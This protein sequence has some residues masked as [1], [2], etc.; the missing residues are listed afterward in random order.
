MV[1]EYFTI[2]DSVNKKYKKNYIA[3]NLP[4]I[5][6]NDIEYAK[7]HEKIIVIFLQE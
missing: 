6:N 3:T 7:L 1:S 5:N 2:F 4:Y